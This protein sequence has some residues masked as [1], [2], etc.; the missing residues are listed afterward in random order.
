MTQM[1]T[2]Y[3]P[4]ILLCRD[5]VY[6]QVLGW[7]DAWFALSTKSLQHQLKIASSPGNCGASETVLTLTSPFEFL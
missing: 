4:F 5:I 2:S 1:I 6:K 3:L 7:V